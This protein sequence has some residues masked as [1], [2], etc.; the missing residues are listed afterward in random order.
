MPDFGVPSRLFGPSLILSFFA[1]VPCSGPKGLKCILADTVNAL[2]VF[3]VPSRFFGPSLVLS[4]FALVRA[5]G[6]KGFEC[7]LAG[8]VNALQA[9]GR[10]SSSK[11]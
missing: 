8:A 10:M 9:L 7:I 1:L 6:W 11:K 2:P 4:F 3:W 5:P